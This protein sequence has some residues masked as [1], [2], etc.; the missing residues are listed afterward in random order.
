MTRTNYTSMCFLSLLVVAAPP[1]ATA[2]KPAANAAQD[3]R[4]ASVL[5]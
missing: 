5:G 1:G 4:G 2:E 3:L